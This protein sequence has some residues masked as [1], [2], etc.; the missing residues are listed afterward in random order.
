MKG[1]KFKICG[2]LMIFIMSIMCNLCACQ[3]KEKTESKT[4]EKLPKLRIGVDVLKPFFYID[5][6]G[7]YK[8]I[9]AEIAKKACELA[10]YQP[11]FVKVEWTKRDE[12]LQSQKVDCLWAALSKDGREDKYQWTETYLRS[13]IRAVSDTNSPSK[14]LEDFQGPGGIAVR[15]GAKPEEIIVSGAD[16]RFQNIAVYSCGTYEMAETA[17][18][19]K[20]ADALACHE[21]VLQQLINE[22]P[23]IYQFLDGTILNAHLAVAFKKDAESDQYKKI[24][25]AIMK[26]KK[27]GTIAKIAEKYGM[28]VME[29]EEV[30]SCENE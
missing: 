21:I 23:G 6:N 5:K 24:N 1:K 27:D 17:F 12:K 7:D 26:M 13:R 9:D 22:N 14:S 4:E 19:K 8:G 29:E 18:I 16:E 25:Q 30:D 15:A 28:D 10:G 3:S 2:L 11:E 20:Y